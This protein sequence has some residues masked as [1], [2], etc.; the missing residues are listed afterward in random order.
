[1]KSEQ[2]VNEWYSN[3]E[4]AHE[5][6]GTP[7]MLKADVNLE[8]A[9]IIMQTEMAVIHCYRAKILKAIESPDQLREFLDFEAIDEDLWSNLSVL[10][11]S[12]V[13]RG[14]IS[15]VDFVIG[16]VCDF[17]RMC[18]RFNPLRFANTIAKAS[19]AFSEV[20]DRVCGDPSSCQHPARG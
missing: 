18:T 11:F 17:V 19:A 14:D 12:L 13:Q 3:I 9:E 2:Q 6:R 5:H 7:E 15:N 8:L 20:A 4:W 1:M 16:R 10:L